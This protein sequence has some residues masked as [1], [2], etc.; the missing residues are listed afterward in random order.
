M[1]TTF[2]DG[3]EKEVDRPAILSLQ[4][5]IVE[6]VGYVD[7]DREQ[8][9]GRYVDLDLCQRCYNLAAATAY[10]VINSAGARP[11]PQETR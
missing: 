11:S 10:A 9:S 1:R 7:R 8:V 6:G 3:C 2:C 5:H 4:C